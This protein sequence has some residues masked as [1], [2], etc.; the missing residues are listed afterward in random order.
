M[1]NDMDYKRTMRKHGLIIAICVI[2][3]IAV[4]AGTSYALFFQVETNSEN[5]VIKTGKLDVSYGSD[6]SK[7]NLDPILPVSDET[8]MTDNNYR[9][10]VNI[11]NNGS[12][13]ASYVLKLKKDLDAVRLA[14]GTASE[15][16]DLQYVKI[17][18]LT[19]S[20]TI[21]GETALNTLTADEGGNYKLYE[22][23]LAADANIN[24]YVRVWLDSTTPET[25]SGKYVYF[26]LDVSS[27]VDEPNTVEGQQAANS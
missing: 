10:K 2:G 17:A 7:I 4:L 15:F 24:I 20:E 11:K 14:G 25:Q 26:K 8:G 1:V 12:L 21:L 3:T 22:G 18:V 13:P 5:Q 6:S 27:V 23:T 9:S 16:V 19:D